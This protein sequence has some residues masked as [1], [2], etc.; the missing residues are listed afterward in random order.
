LNWSNRIASQQEIRMPDNQEGK[1][2]SYDEIRRRSVQSVVWSFFSNILTKIITPLYTIILARLLSPEDYGIIAI[3]A[4]VIALLN[5]LQTMGLGQALVQRNERVEKAANVVFW[6]N[7]LLSITLY[8]G[9]YFASPFVSVFF[10]EPRAMAVIRVM[11]IQLVIGAFGIVQEALLRHQL[12]FKKLFWFQLLPSV[13]PGIVCILLA[14][15]GWGYWSLVY[16]TLI[17]TVIGVIILW[18]QSAWRPSFHIDA[19]LAKQLTIFGTMV[20]IET[21]ASWIYDYFDNMVVGHYLGIQELGIYSLGYRIV[22]MVIM[23]FVL[24]VTNVAYSSFSRMQNDLTQLQSLFQ[25]VTRLIAMVL[26]PVCLGLATVS[27]SV[28]T[29]LFGEKWEGLGMI[30]L[31]ISIMPGL[32][33]LWFLVP[34]VFRAIGRPDINAK[35]GIGFLLYVIPLFLLTAPHGLQVFLIARMSVGFVTMPIIIYLTVRYLKVPYNFLWTCSREPFTASCI[36][37]AVVYASTEILKLSFGCISLP[38]LVFVIVIGALTYTIASL[39]INRDDTLFVIGKIKSQMVL[40]RAG[41]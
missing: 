9:L 40:R 35:M 27:D 13:I 30:L 39:K 2:S 1:E 18:F 3:A 25:R 7:L 29:V 22:M 16:G 28:E 23:F 19:G 21:S 31:A 11:G 26:I 12:N 20:M 37:M 24:P 33:F 8:I 17:G 34:Q 6:F 14:L 10:K 36:M 5:I 41:V 38:G 15:I 32:S 4:L